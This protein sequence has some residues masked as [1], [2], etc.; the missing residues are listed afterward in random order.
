MDAR[1]L[2]PP[3]DGAGMGG[4]PTVLHG[5]SGDGRRGFQQR[6]VDAVLLIGKRVDDDQ[7]VI[8]VGGCDVA[9]HRDLLFG[10]LRV[11]LAEIPVEREGVAET[12]DQL[13][14]IEFSLRAGGAAVERLRQCRRPAL[15]AEVATG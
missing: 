7:V 2:A 8:R 11:L 12:G 6:A 4:A 3:F 9:G 1:G 5:N 10:A 13:S 14:E 15:G